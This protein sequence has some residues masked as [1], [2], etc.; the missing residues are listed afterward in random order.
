MFDYPSIAAMTEYISAKL[1]PAEADPV[2][3]TQAVSPVEA[4]DVVGRS[5]HQYRALATGI[6]RSH[7]GML[8]DAGCSGLKTS[9][10]IMT[11]PAERWDVDTSPA[12]AARYGSYLRDVAYFDSSV[13]QISR[14]EAVLMDAQHRFI[15]EQ[16]YET[17][18]QHPSLGKH[19]DTFGVY[20]GIASTD[21]GQ[22]ALKYTGPAVSVYSAT[23]MQLSVAAGR[24][25]YMFGLKGPSMSIDT[26]CSSSLVAAHLGYGGLRSGVCSDAI[27]CGVA[28]HLSAFTTAMFKR[29]GMLAEDGRC[30][31][32]D[33]TADG[34][35][36]S[37][38][39][40]TLLLRHCESPGD[41]CSDGLVCSTSVNQ[42][43]RSSS[44]TAPNGPSQQQVM[45]SALRFVG[46]EGDSL[47]SL[48]MHGT[49]TSLGDP[50]EIGA[51]CAVLG[52]G[53]ADEASAG[54]LLAGV[55][56][57]CGHSEPAAGV[58]GMIQTLSAQSL[59]MSAPI[60]HLRSLNEHVVNVFELEGSRPAVPRQSAMWSTDDTVGDPLC[61]SSGVSSFAFQGTNAFA[62]LGGAVVAGAR[63][64][65]EPSS[66]S[67]GWRTERY[68]YAPIAAALCDSARADVSPAQSI[69]EVRLSQAR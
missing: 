24:L 8:G 43:G 2:A 66:A 29:A 28:M 42:D 39:C 63:S 31:V 61:Y 7:Q 11:T 55:K 67:K 51:A 52:S 14:R 60:M 22:N 21:Y 35:V 57:C 65:G 41:D 47:R 18:H 46:S 26:A 45:R 5:G 27:V 17:I 44:L 59:R 69:V 13:F 30:K 56:S 12:P 53:G 4:V 16:S 19:A 58:T 33:S 34:Y 68:W 9:D 6:T 48:Q 20:V 3:S 37:E 50:I 62:V 32:L 38:S 10:S 36:R 23:G 1:E 25:S 40:G 49:G 54:L 64:L 15:L